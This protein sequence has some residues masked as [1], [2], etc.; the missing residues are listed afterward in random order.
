MM[1]TSR[2]RTFSSIFTKIWPS[3]NR[4]IVTAHSG[5]PKCCAI[6]SARGRLAVPASSNSWLRD[7]VKS[8]IG[9][10]KNRRYVWRNEGVLQRLQEPEQRRALG[11]KQRPEAVARA[12]GLARVRLDR[13][14]ERG[15]AP[16]VQEVRGRV[17]RDEGLGAEVGRPREP[18]T[19][20]G[21]VRSHVVQ[22]QVGVG[23]DRLVTQRRDRTVAG[24]ERGHVARR[25]A[26]APERRAAALALAAEPRGRRRGEEAH[27]VVGEIGLFL[28]DLRVGDGI[29]A[30]RDRLAADV[31]FGRLRGGGD[32]H[33]RDERAGGELVE[34]GAERLGAEAAE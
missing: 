33:F 4:R 30:R 27:E 34:T 16:V 23:G 24:R 14:L 5:C 7:S 29:D 26:D 31:F 9:A 8:A 1:K 21:E 2:P 12:G 6:S 20:I 28:R 18:E 22:Q 15:R 25:A 17:Q 11:R 13:L 10:A 32:P 3:A 19:D